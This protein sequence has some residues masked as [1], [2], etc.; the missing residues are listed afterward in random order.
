VGVKFEPKDPPRRF[1]V[2]NAVKF[3]MKDCG[4]VRLAA[5]EQVTFATESG[6]EYDVARKDW[7]F[8]ATPSLNGRL[9]QFGLR[10][11]LIKN[12]GTGRYFVLLVERGREAGFNAYCERENLAVVTWLDSSA[13]LDDLARKVA[14]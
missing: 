12:R 14:G 10:G 2:G 7:G 5:D 3:E 4:T 13:A 1:P 8:Y 11:V 6:A 9:E